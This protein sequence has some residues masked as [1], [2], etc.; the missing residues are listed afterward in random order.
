M[1]KSSDALGSSLITGVVV[2]FRFRPI[3][4]ERDIVTN[5]AHI[6]DLERRHQALEGEI[7]KALFHCSTDDL[8]IVDLK[9]RKLDLR[10]EIERLRH[11]AVRNGRPNYVRALIK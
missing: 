5:P 9:R 4:C 8:M 11:E 6:A 1:R 10:D 2:S 7:S 3:H